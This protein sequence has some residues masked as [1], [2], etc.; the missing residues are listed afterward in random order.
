[1][2]AT[3][4][5]SKGFL[6]RRCRAMWCRND[7]TSR[8]DSCTSNAAVNCPRPAQT[9]RLECLQ[10]LVLMLAMTLHSPL[11]SVQRLS[12]QMLGQRTESSSSISASVV[13]HSGVSFERM[14]DCSRSLKSIPLDQLS[15][16]LSLWTTSARHHQVLAHLS[17]E[18]L[19]QHGQL[20]RK[21]TF[22]MQI[23]KPGLP[24]AG[25]AGK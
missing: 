22:A 23:T 19:Q 16:T 17:Q 15:L 3:S 20:F 4:L 10:E 8:S 24:T 9:A 11:P 12:I 14:M 13:P 21:G 7:I 2:P 25:P 6:T 5:F 18:R 1:M